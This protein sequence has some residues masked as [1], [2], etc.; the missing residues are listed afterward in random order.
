MPIHGAI[1]SAAP[2]NFER[3]ISES[4]SYRSAIF[5]SRRLVAGNLWLVDGGWWLDIC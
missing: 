2:E 5:M 1:F 4:L 3:L